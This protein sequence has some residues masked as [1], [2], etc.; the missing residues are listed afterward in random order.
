MRIELDSK[1]LERMAAAY[2][3]KVIDKALVRTLNETVTT[4]KK[5]AVKAV[6][7]VYN[8]KAA[9]IN[10]KIRIKRATQEWKNNYLYI[11]SQP[12]GLIH[13]GATA[14]KAFDRGS[15][16]YFKTKA[17]VLKTDRKKLVKGAFIGRGKTSG[18]WQVFRRT[19]SKRLPIRKLSVISPTSMF[20]KYGVKEIENVFKDVFADRFYKNLNFYMSKAK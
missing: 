19:G 12:I 15:K 3:P 4:G 5:E 7:S 20:E 14:S 2:D 8:I 9:D 1:A 16:R 13:F 11:K 10:S 6:R 18:P 17:K